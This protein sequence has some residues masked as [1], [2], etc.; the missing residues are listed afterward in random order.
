LR[1]T[2]G[3]FH[4]LQDWEKERWSRQT[5]AWKFSGVEHSGKICGGF[6]PVVGAEI[7][8]AEEPNRRKKPP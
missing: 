8:Q 7:D 6:S 5:P 2:A 1:R 4:I 3:F